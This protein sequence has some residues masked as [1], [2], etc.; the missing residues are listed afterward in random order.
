MQGWQPISQNEGGL[1]T[2]Q[3]QRVMRLLNK[4]S[5]AQLL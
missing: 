3:W 4:E 5:L 2:A 1:K